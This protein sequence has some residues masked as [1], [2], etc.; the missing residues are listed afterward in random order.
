MGQVKSEYNI[1]VVRHER[2][3]NMSDLGINERNLL[4]R[5]DVDKSSAQDR[6]YG[7]HGKEPPG[8]ITSEQ[9]FD[10]LRNYCLI[11]KYSA[12]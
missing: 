11:E 6:V 1:V 12:P 10:H 5:K 9:L 8:T 4:K 7:G 3:D 2:K